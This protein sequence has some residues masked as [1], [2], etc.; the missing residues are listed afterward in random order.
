MLWHMS[1]GL[2]AQVYRHIGCAYVLASFAGKV[3][4]HS[5]AEIKLD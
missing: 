1:R 2:D 3:L 5:V 4:H